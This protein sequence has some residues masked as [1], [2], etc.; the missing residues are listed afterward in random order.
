MGRRR[1]FTIGHSTRSEAEFLSLLRAHAVQVVVDVRRFP[2]ARCQHFSRDQLARILASQGL[3]HFWLGHYLGGY[4]PGGYE[5][6]MK[7]REFQRGLS[8]L[9]TVASRRTTAIMC[10]EKLFFR[11][12]RRFIADA[13][14]AHGWEVIHIVD[15][16]RWQVHRLRLDQP[17]LL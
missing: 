7:T 4:R 6:W 16:T 13:L 14:T 11:C 5:E 17:T 15:D 3:R 2:T 12:H 10:A 9:E 1:V 8:F